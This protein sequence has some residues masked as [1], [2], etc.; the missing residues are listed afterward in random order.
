MFIVEGI[1]DGMDKGEHAHQPFACH[2]WHAHR[3]FGAGLFG[4][5]IFAAEPAFILAGIGYQGGLA[6]LHHPAGEAA[7]H[8]LT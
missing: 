3:G 1:G 7:F 8:G 4:G 5:I 6:M 2:Q